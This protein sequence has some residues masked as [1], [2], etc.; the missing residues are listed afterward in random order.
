MKQCP[1]CGHYV[2]DAARFCDECGYKF[3]ANNINDEL[4]NTN[5]TFER[6]DSK[7]KKENDRRRKYGIVF[8]AFFIIVGCSLYY[9][10]GSPS[11]QDETTAKNITG[12]WKTEYTDKENGEGLKSFL[13]FD[14]SEDQRANGTINI[15]VLLNDNF[16]TEKGTP[17]S[18]T[19]IITEKGIWEI[20]SGM[21]VIT[22]LSE[23]EKIEPANFDYR[24]VSAKAVQELTLAASLKLRTNTS[25]GERESKFT[26]ESVGG[27]GLVLINE[28]NERM[29]FQ[30]TSKQEFEQIQPDNNTAALKKEQEEARKANQRA[31]II[32]KWRSRFVGYSY[33]EM[34]DDATDYYIS[35][36]FGS[37][38]N[39]GAG[40][41]IISDGD[42]NERTFSYTLLDANKVRCTFKNGKSFLLQYSP[43]G[44]KLDGYQF[45][46]KHNPDSYQYYFHGN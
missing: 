3:A 34:T 23:T 44:I 9:K 7:G 46:H 45:I 37:P 20:K 11:H 27:E 32:R 14:T 28:N 8:L 35:A 19:F 33:N 22:L 18:G 4:S 25:L 21:L 43:N 12:V 26:I 5:N 31:N 2:A 16:T 30:K 15:K 29:R 40:I 17:C 42:D 41:G 39:D 6:I 36:F 38:D 10:F 1:N 24:I 13:D